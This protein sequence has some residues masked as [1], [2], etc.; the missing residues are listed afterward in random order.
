MPHVLVVVSF[1]LSVFPLFQNVETGR[2][3]FF[4]SWQ[5]S[6]WLMM[7]PEALSGN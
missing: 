4:G 3:S 2:V 5:L 7:M 1:F 6:G